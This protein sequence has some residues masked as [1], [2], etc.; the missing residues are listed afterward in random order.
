VLPA[1]AVKM[2]SLLCQPGRQSAWRSERRTDTNFHAGFAPPAS[3][4]YGFMAALPRTWIPVPQ[5]GD[6]PYLIGWRHDRDRA[7]LT[8]CE[9]DLAVELADDHASYVRLLRRTTEQIAASP[10]DR[11][12]FL[13]WLDKTLAC[14]PDT[15]ADKHATPMA[16]ED[17]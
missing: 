1:S 4:G 7:V 10:K 8:Y 12:A 11:D 17:A 15:D 3:D 5:W 14:R 9:G 13:A 16:Q 2:I 6:W